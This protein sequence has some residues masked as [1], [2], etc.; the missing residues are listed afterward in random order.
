M[1]HEIKTTEVD[2]VFTLMVMIW[3]WICA[4]LACV[5]FGVN[6]I[7]LQAF[8]IILIPIS[9]IIVVMIKSQAYNEDFRFWRYM[10]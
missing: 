1:A 5:I 7:M 8:M 9:Y 3:A 2:I 10:Q 6:A 4:I